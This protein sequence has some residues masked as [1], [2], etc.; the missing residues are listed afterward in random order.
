MLSPERRVVRWMRMSAIAAALGDEQL[1][2][3]LSEAYTALADGLTAYADEAH[4]SGLLQLDADPR[5]IALLLSMHSQGLVLDDLVDADVPLESWNHLMV[6]FVSS[7]LTPSAADALEGQETARFGD[8][9]RAEVFGEPGRLPR[10][11]SDRMDALRRAEP[12]GASA[13]T[14]MGDVAQVRAL[15]ERAERDGR[16]GSATRPGTPNRALRD[17]VLAAGML[18]LRTQGEVGVDVV[19]LRR[20]VDLSPQSF[21]RMFGSREA[22]VRELRIRLE[23][24][25]SANSIARF[26]RLVAASAGPSEM[27]QALERDGVVMHE[28]ASRAAM[29]QR[30]ETLDATRTDPE[31]RI[32]L[33]RV[34]RA[35]RD[36]LIEQVCL[37]QRRGLMDPEL[38]ARSVARLLDGTVFWHV[39]YGLDARRPP[40][41]AWIGMLRRIAMLLSPDA[42]RDGDPDLRR[43]DRATA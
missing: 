15:L 42:S 8:L 37:A 4:R 32:S 33:A 11:V 14:E 41:D 17:Q 25:R 21:H 10:D 12:D 26:A 23:T 5:T 3:T 31:L 6:R 43:A 35:T 27:R 34:Q 40:R 24:S 22:F 18:A 29:W 39:F 1:T 2:E 19:T 36:L 7:F 38:P 16:N 13:A 30:I 9:W 28:E 20:D